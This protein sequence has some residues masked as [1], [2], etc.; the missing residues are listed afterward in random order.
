MIKTEKIEYQDGD[1]L[2][3]GF[4]AYNGQTTGKLPAILVCH[5]WS[6]KNAFACDKA[7]QLAK[8]GYAGFALDMYGKGKTGNT[9]EEKAA[10]MQPLIDDR[11]KLQ[12]R[13]LAAFDTVKNLAPVDSKRIGAIGFCF[14]GLCVLDLARSGADVRAVVSF[15][16]LLHAPDTL[17]QPSI[18]AKILALHGYDDPMVTP[19]KVTAFCNE[20]THAGADW[21]L[22]MYGHTMHAFTNPQANDPGFGTVYNEKADMRSWAAMREFFKEVFEI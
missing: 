11:T 3:E 6:G 21:Q 10:L 7:E 9:K 4:F 5:D 17:A 20:M 13:I 15:H 19:E 12:Q 18:K 1:V 14:G 22:D 2:L 16:G 8:L